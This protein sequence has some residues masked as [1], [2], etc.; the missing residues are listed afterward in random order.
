M[1]L[2]GSAIFLALCVWAT[3]V[4]AVLFTIDWLAGAVFAV[5]ATM[6]GASGIAMAKE[7]LKK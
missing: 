5:I 6:F 2:L 4:S 7:I 1:K 3:R